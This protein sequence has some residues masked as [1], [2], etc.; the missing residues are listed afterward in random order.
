MKA[1]TLAVVGD[2]ILAAQLQLPLL[3]IMNKEYAFIKEL[4]A[5]VLK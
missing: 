4:K 5:K 1:N 3:P 2:S